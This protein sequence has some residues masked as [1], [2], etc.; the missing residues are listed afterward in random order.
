MAAMADS[1]SLSSFI[2]TKPKPRER[3][4]SR[5]VMMLTRPT[6]PY[7]SNNVRSSSSV[8]LKDR[9]PTKILFKRMFPSRLS[10]LTGGLCGRRKRGRVL[11]PGKTTA[12]FFHPDGSRS[13]A[14]TDYRSVGGKAN[15]PMGGGDQILPLQGSGRNT[16]TGTFLK[17][18][19]SA[20]AASLP[21]E[22][23][24]RGRRDACSRGSWGTSPGP[25]SPARAYRFRK[26]NKRR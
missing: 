18:E 8:V 3:P 22:S 23:I 1:A 2:S 19:R 24:R 14:N 6:L 10:C 17:R 21:F 16:A 11:Q 5:S 25:S 13:N 12:G 15:P 7:G 20:K 26:S 4:V 9:L